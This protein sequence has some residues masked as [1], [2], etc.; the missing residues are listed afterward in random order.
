MANAGNAV[1]VFSL[2][3]ML[4]RR[5]WILIASTLLSG[6]GFA[7]FARLQ[8]DKYRATAVIAATQSTA[9][10]YL[11]RVA[12]PL[13]IEDHLWVVREV[14]YSDAVLHAA[15]KE[16]RSYQKVEGILSPQQLE[17]L[18]EAISIKVDTEHSFQ[19]TFE[20]GDR[21]DAMNVANKLASLFVQKAS[22]KRE[23]NTSEA[24]NVINEQ[25]NALKK[26][27]QEKSR[28]MHDYKTKAVHALPDHIDT[29]LKAIDSTRDQIRDLEI[30]IAEE[31]AKK[32]STQQELQDLESKGVL[33]QPVIYEKGADEM[34]L[35]ELR[36]QLTQLETRYTPRHPNIV[37]LK[38]QIS[39]LEGAVAA[40]SKKKSSEPSQ[41]YLRYAQ[42]KSELEGIDQRIQAYRKEQQTLTSQLESYSRLLESTPQHEKVIDDLDRDLK[43]GETQFRTLL[44]KQ[45]DTKLT[46]GFEQSKSGIAFSIVEPARLPQAPFSPQRLRLA[47][48]G[49]TAGL[50]LGLGLVFVLEQN[51]T[52]FSNVDDLQSFTTLPVAG[53]VP[54]IRGVKNKTHVQTLAVTIEDPGSVAAEQYR[55][56]AMRVRQQC[57]LTQARTIMITSAAGGEGK[58]LTAINLAAALASTADGRVLLVDAD[59]RKPKIAEYLNLAIGA[60]SGF[61][62]LLAEGDAEPDNHVR[63]FSDIDVIAGGVC[64]GNPVAILS[65]PKARAVFE[66]LKSQFAYVIVDAPPVLPIADSHILAGLVDKV[67]LVVRAQKTP[68][69]L[70]QQAVD[71]FEPASLLGAVLN[72]IDYQRSRY[73]YAY[74]YYKK[75][76]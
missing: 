39:D 48:L 25:V 22:A 53:V 49:V 34:K 16:S 2:L 75:S 11:L 27:L 19:V 37:A 71:G 60:G 59:M 32:A 14:L 74:E 47:L 12:P 33:D 61:Y 55:I 44:D 23:Q 1:S 70:F 31:Q 73:A 72:D 17:E 13:R 15:A 43:T 6:A 62:G 8:P 38:R 54:N 51:D 35:E 29:N 76:A 63:R 3:G 28:Q 57:D 46:Q 26:E 5:K 9:P 67:L 24:A 42:L 66:R 20:A 40:Q 65:S 69:E 10:E 30:K 36:F 45:L 58:S 64:P 50:G 7:V 56:L 68:R 4:R 41:T 18:K 52:S 21:Y